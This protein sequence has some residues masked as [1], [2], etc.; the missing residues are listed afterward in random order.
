MSNEFNTRRSAVDQIVETEALAWIAQL[1]GD[2]ITEKDLGAFR[3]WLNRS[4]AH[5]QK[6]IELNSFWEE[7][8]VMTE[9]ADDIAALDYVSSQLR[10]KNRVWWMRP[11]VYGPALALSM[12]A[13]FSIAPVMV[14]PRTPTTPIVVADVNLPTIY[15]SKVGEQQVHTLVDGSILTLNTGSHVEVDYRD[16]QRRIRLLQGEA[17]FDVEHDPLRPFLVFAGDGVVRAVGTAFT[18]HLDGD[19]VDVMVSEGSVELSSVLPQT[20]D[21]PETPTA[22]KVATLGIIKA[23]HTARVKNAEASISSLTEEDISAKLSWKDG[24]VTFRGETLEEVIQEVGRYTNLEIKIMDEE[25][26]RMQFGGVFKTGDTETL[27]ENLEAGFGVA[28]DT[29]QPGIVRLSKL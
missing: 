10:R 19:L 24:L 7:L 23:G 17:L 3:E 16:K 27:F 26:N 12:L 21:K 6:M 29:S 4:P 11:I 18:V 22:K 2:S 25:L 13:V 28:I 5:A 8:N 15:K 9:M 14:S 1:D 20:S